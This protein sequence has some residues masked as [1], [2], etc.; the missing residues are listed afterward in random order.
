[1]FQSELQQMKPLISEDIYRV[2]AGLIDRCVHATAST[3][4]FMRASADARDYATAMTDA[5]ATIDEARGLVDGA[6]TLITSRLG[7][8][9]P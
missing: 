8:L 4:D 2:C 6:R 1:V 5:K 7:Q 9:T 3:Q